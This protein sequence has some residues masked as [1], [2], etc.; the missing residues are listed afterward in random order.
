MK[1]WLLLALAFIVVTAS[2]FVIHARLT[3]STATSTHVTYV[4]VKTHLARVPNS[5]YKYDLCGE[6][7]AFAKATSDNPYKTDQNFRDPFRDTGDTII[8]R[9]L[10]FDKVTGEASFSVKIILDQVATFN[11]TISHVQQKDGISILIP[12]QQD[13]LQHSSV[14]QFIISLPSAGG[15]LAVL[16]FTCPQQ[17]VWSAMPT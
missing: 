5:A 16:D 11:E 17:W 2:I 12:N 15:D 1:R 4:K 14:P 10:G 9:F 6:A 7:F 8:P 3:T 13:K